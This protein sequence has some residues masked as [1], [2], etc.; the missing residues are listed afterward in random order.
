MSQ[1]TEFEL[2]YEGNLG[3][4]KIKLAEEP[5]FATTKDTVDSY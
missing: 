4:L 3:A 5:K 1:K 2:A